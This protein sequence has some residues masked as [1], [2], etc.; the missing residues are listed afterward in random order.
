MKTTRGLAAAA[1]IAALAISTTGALGDGADVS[2]PLSEMRASLRDADSR[3]SEDV[4]QSSTDAR[5]PEYVLQRADVS[6]PEGFEPVEELTPELA[7]PSPTATIEAAKQEPAAIVE[8]PPIKSLVREQ[9][10]KTAETDAK[11]DTLSTVEIFVQGWTAGG[12]DAVS[13]RLVVC[14]LGKESGGNPYA[15]NAAGPFYGLM[16]FLLSTWDAMGG[17]DWRDPYTQGV[18]TAKLWK[19]AAPASQWPAAYRLCT[20]GG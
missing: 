18:N 6:A 13:V 2:Q 3:A 10:T 15:Y 8:P 16:Q 11:I 5:L 14:I 9:L 20:A 4:R 1:A 19:A 17:G 7:T 12:G